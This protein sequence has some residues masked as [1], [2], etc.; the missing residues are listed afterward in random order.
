MMYAFSYMQAQ[1]K[2]DSTPKRIS[3]PAYKLLLEISWFNLVS[4]RSNYFLK[5]KNRTYLFHKNKLNRFRRH[6]FDNNINS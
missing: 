3:D 1:Q 6:V 4:N 2:T 5:D